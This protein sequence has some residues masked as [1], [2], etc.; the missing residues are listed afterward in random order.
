MINTN[1]VE[2][3]EIVRDLMSYALYHFDTEEALMLAHEYP[4]EAQQLHFQEHRAFSAKIAKI[5]DDISRGQQVSSQ[6]LLNFLNT[7]LINHIM[8]ADK[9]MAEFL[10]NTEN[11]PL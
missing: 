9:Q 4:D 10:L 1:R 5:Q 7:W 2:L 11:G 3:E 8:G 6:D